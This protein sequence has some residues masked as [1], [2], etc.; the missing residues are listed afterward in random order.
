VRYSPILLV[1]FFGLLSCVIFPIPISGQQNSDFQSIEVTQDGNRFDVMAAMTN[2]D[3]LTGIQVNP[4]YGSILISLETGSEGQESELRLV[5]PR[6]LID[7]R[8]LGTDSKFD[9]VVEGEPTEYTELRTTD[10]EREIKILLPGGTS[11]I[12]I[13]GNQIV[14]EFPTVI[15]VVTISF[16]IVISAITLLRKEYFWK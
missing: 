7:S 12:E 11:Q 4:D 8:D 5:L 2:G 6:D 1:A 10:T 16:A 15:V 3:K 9:V 13:F 14:P